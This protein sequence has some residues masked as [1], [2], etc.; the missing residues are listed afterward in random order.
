MLVA[1]TK[2]GELSRLLTGVSGCEITGLTVTPDRRTMF[3]NVQHP[4]NGDPSATNFPVMNDSPDGTTI[5]RDATIVI[6]KKDGG[7][8]GS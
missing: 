2:T 4:G 8:I 7:V 3:V 1:D 6:T 5:P